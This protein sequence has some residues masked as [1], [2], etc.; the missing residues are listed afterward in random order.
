MLTIILFAA[1]VVLTLIDQLTKFWAV[2]ELHHADRVISVIDGVFELRYTE[3]PGVAFGQLSGQG[4]FFIPLTVLFIVLFVIMLLR[5]PLRTRLLFSI[6][7]ACI[8]AGALGNLIDRIAYGYVVDFLYVR[9]IDFPIF[10]FAD[11]CVVIGA[12]VLFIFFLFVW[13]DD[14]MPLRTMVFGIEV[15]EKESNDG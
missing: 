6:P 4:W 15:A 2:A 9:L 10:N 12:I 13:K 5:S 7:V 8:T 14:S 1:V 11:C 3:N